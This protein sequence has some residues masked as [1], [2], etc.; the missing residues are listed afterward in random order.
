MIGGPFQAVRLRKTEPFCNF[1][2]LTGEWS[3]LVVD[4]RKR[5]QTNNTVEDSGL[6]Y[7]YTP[8]D[9]TSIE[10]SQGGDSGALVA[11]NGSS[12]RH[13]KAR[14][15]AGVVCLDAQWSAFGIGSCQ[16]V[17]HGKKRSVRRSLCCHKQRSR[18][19]PGG[20]Q[21]GLQY[22]VLGGSY[23]ATVL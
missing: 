8:V 16:V 22:T 5:G 13:V 1:H 18:I 17:Q 23:V 10:K 2:P 11:W 19:G 15:T 14:N 21:K 6:L 12:T 4:R 9:V 20:Y 3:G 7:G